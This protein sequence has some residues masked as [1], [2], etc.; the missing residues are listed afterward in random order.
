[1]HVALSCKYT[2]K[3]DGV[4]FRRQG[5]PVAPDP[6]LDRR[7]VDFF[8]LKIKGDY[9]NYVILY[10]IY[11]I[12]ATVRIPHRM[13]CLPKTAFTDIENKTFTDSASVDEQSAHVRRQPGMSEGVQSRSEKSFP[14]LF[15]LRLAT[16]SR[17]A[18]CTLAVLYI[19]HLSDSGIAHSPAHARH[20]CGRAQ[21]GACRLCLH[22]FSVS[23]LYRT[24]FD[25]VDY[26]R[27]NP[28]KVTLNGSGLFV[29]GGRS[30]CGQACQGRNGQRLLPALRRQML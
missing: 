18:L 26:A 4:C 10:Y 9:Y 24:V 19:A 3:D 14:L 25:M 29:W 21:A 7:T 15:R 22:R 27:A 2:K 8:R 20:P 23:A 13:A 12:R 17:R 6:V 11:K 16:F 1:M 28:G 5:Q 30:V